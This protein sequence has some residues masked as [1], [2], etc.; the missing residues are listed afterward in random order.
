VKSPVMVVAEKRT[1]NEAK[2][3][4]VKP[5]RLPKGH[6]VRNAF[7]TV[8]AE[9]YAPQLIR[10]RRNP[11]SLH[12]GYFRKMKGGERAKM[13]SKLRDRPNVA[14]LVAS[15]RREERVSLPR[16]TD[17]R[18]RVQARPRISADAWLGGDQ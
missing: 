17:S 2:K 7:N 4:L 8:R 3:E 1:K 14:E 13:D 9:P 5:H 6:K 15:S 11:F 18:L 16:A 12:P 10:L